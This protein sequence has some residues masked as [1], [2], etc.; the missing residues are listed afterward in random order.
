MDLL[1][2]A[3][4]GQA[5]G[6]VDRVVGTVAGLGREFSFLRGNKKLGNQ[7]R[8]RM[9]SLRARRWERG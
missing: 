4:G 8:L 6:R 2:E 1:W 9:G 3:E 7:L 5:G